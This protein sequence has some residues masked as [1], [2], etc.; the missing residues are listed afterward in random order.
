MALTIASRWL[1]H[2]HVNS[3][4]L[5]VIRGRGADIIVLGCRPDCV[6]VMQC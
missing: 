3:V 2:G 5:A 6:A 1:G 4:Q